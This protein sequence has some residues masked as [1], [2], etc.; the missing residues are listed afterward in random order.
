M[1]SKS[2]NQKLKHLRKA[3][4]KEKKR[5][6]ISEPRFTI[7]MDVRT[8]RVTLSY[9]IPVDGG[10]DEKN[11]RIVRKKQVRKYLKNVYVDDVDVVVNKLQTYTDEIL[12]DINLKYKSIGSEKDTLKHWMRVYTENPKRKGNIEVVEST[13]RY[14]KVAINDLIDWCI[15]Q[16]KTKYLNIWNWSEDG[17]EL[18]LEYFKY[19]QE[20]GGQKVKWSDGGVNSSYRRIRAFFNFISENVDGF[21]SQLLNRLPVKRTKV[22]TET[23]T[24]M[25]MELIIQFLEEN[26]DEPRWSWFVPI[27]KVLLETGMRVSEVVSMKIRDVDIK[28]QKC[29]I[30]G[31]GNKQRWVY[32][33]SDSVWEIIKNQIYDEDGKIRTDTEWVFWSKYYQKGYGRRKKKVTWRLYERK[34]KPIHTSGIQHKTKDM[35]RE[36]KLSEKLSTHSTRRW[37]ITEMLKKTSG[38]IP[39]VAQLVG[40]NTWDVVRLY[41]KDVVDDTMELNVGLFDK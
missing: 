14:D 5:L 30:V 1:L 16:K 35:I 7:Q 31:K 21:P 11:N 6:R 41:T 10:L 27:F 17:R 33:Q 13:L 15:E 37:F 22:R 18:L 9:S 38:N 28:D 8:K 32:F 40:H 39:L 25:E 20:V 24:S 12:R 23:F 3:V 34:H 19:R 29:K 26:K 36:L 2:D 4:E